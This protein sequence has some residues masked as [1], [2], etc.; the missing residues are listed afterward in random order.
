MSNQQ[1]SK[2]EMVFE[3]AKAIEALRLLDRDQQIDA[4]NEIRDALSEMSAFHGE[5]VDRV[6]WVKAE[7]VSANDYNRLCAKHS[8]T[9]LEPAL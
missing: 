2:D 6:R 9:D 5:P 4:I 7:M 3:V 8:G 1:M